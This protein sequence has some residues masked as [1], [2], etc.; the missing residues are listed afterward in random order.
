LPKFYH[1]VAPQVWAWGARRAKKFAKI[2]D[3]LFAFFE[4]EVPYFTKYNLDTVAVGHP[5]AD[6]LLGRSIRPDKNTIALLPGSRMSEVTRLMPIYRDV[7]AALP[8]H[9][10]IIPTVET[11][12]DYIEKCIRDWRVKPELIDSAARYDLYARAN[13][14][15]TASGTASAE[16]AMMHVPAIVVYKMNP[17]TMWLGRR[18]I[19]IRWVSLVNILLGRS[20]YP[21]L[22]G[23]DANPDN[24]ISWI[25]KLSAPA[26]RKEMINELMAA[27]KLWRPSGDKTVAGVIAEKVISNQ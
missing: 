26:A 15:V 24:I 1:V 19:K 27:D 23:S 17:I 20:V 25:K 11:T 16:L 3:K 7:V 6:D 22:L 12:R 10:F 4:F 9:E 18:L 14:A 13:I 5:L 2:F 8:D 21:E